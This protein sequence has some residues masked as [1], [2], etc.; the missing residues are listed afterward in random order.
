MPMPRFGASKR[1]L[2]LQTQLEQQAETIALLKTSLAAETQARERADRGMVEAEK[3]IQQ[4]QIAAREAESHAQ[5]VLAMHST[6]TLVAVIQIDPQEIFDV[7]KQVD[8]SI[9]VDW[10]GWKLHIYARGE[11]STP[12]KNALEARL[13]TLISIF[14]T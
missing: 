12:T 2:D 11:M 3:R 7:L 6:E 5:Q 10:V 1:K 13:H 8:S 9:R 4:E 14:R